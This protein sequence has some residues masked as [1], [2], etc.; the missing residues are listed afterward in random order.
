MINLRRFFENH[1]RLQRLFFLD[2]IFINASMILTMGMFISGYFVYL[3]GSDFLTGVINSSQNWATMAALFSF[4]FYERMVYRKKL[5]IGILAA[6]R[7]FVCSIVFLPLIFN[8]NVQ[9]LTIASVMVI[10][11]NILWGV[12]ANGYMVWL[13]G[14]SNRDDRNQFFYTRT[15][16]LR[17]SFTIATIVMGFVLDWYN[18]SYTGFLV[19]FIVSLALAAFDIAVIVQI[20]EKPHCVK[21]EF[22]FSW[23]FFFKPILDK[24]F[25]RYLIFISLFYISL[26]MS[27]A[28]SP[29]YLLKYLKLDYSF[30]SS[31]TV[32]MYFV[33]IISTGVWKRI[34]QKRGSNFVFRTTAIFVVLEFLI[35]SFLVR[36]RFYLLF[37]SPIISG[38]GNSGFN[39]C[40]L[41]YR[42][43]LMPEEN[44]TIYEG[45]YSAVYGIGTLIAP[46]LGG[47]LLHELPVIG[48]VIYQNGNFQL[49]Y[50]ISFLCSAFVIGF[51]FF[52]PKKYRISRIAD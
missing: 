33:M 45:W 15:L 44:Q 19:V 39:I 32:G 7:L 41:T 47:F 2:G 21:Q 31:V 8:N 30:I 34:E 3:K 26:T 14:A 37:L 51:F 38:I 24:P 40:T 16:L 18:K 49:L 10:L 48:N 25:R 11:G 20:E 46:V 29:L 35:F 28:F 43:E 50:L 5:L 12:Y 6:S 42:Y 9:V 23:P 17:I 13:A 52:G 4:I 22:R 36:D 1:T 27:S